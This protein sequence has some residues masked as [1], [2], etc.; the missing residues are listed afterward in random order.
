MA[1]G[2]KMGLCK[3]P[4]FSRNAAGLLL[5]QQTRERPQTLKDFLQCRNGFKGTFGKPQFNIRPSYL[6]FLE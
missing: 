4:R 1:A 5:L 2:W 3:E 6:G